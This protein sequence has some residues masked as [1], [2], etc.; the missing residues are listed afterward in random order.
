MEKENKEESKQDYL[1]EK[2]IF[3]QIY[4]QNR[5]EEEESRMK[6]RCLWLKSGD[7]NTNF[8]YNTMKIRRERN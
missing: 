1:Q 6:S 3:L 8:F 2:E 4:K 5:K 7:K